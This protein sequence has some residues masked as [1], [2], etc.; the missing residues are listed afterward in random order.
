MCCFPQKLQHPS[1]IKDIW[2][3]HNERKTENS[4]DERWNAL[5]LLGWLGYT[6][7][8]R[9]KRESL[10]TDSCPLYHCNKAT[11]HFNEFLLEG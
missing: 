9:E 3:L 11:V 2:Q 10:V 6:P 1:T 8:F 4:A 7:C 5:Q